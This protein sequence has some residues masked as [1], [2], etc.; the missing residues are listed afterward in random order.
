MGEWRLSKP[1]IAKADELTINSLLS[2]L[3]DLKMQR[4]LDEV[5]GDKIKEFG[6][7]KPQFTLEFQADG[8]THEI[9]FGHKVPGDQSIYAQKD[10]EARILLIRI[11]DKET[12]DRT[13]TD[14][15]TKKIF[16]LPPEKVTQ[17][18]LIRHDSLILQKTASSGWVAENN[19]PIKLRADKINSLI[20]Q[21][22]S[23]RALEFVAEKADDLKKYGL[24]PSP[25]L[26]LTLLTGDQQEETLLLG[27]K[28]GN[29]YYAQVSGTTPIT[30]VDQTLVEKL[31]SS[32]ETLEDRRLW[33]GPDTEI[34]K[35]VW[36][37]PNKL[38]TA[39]RDP[40]GWSM[41]NAD[42]SPARQESAM[43]FSLAFWRLKDLEFTKLLPATDIKKEKGSVFS[44][45][46][47][48]AEDK[49]LFKLEEFSEEKDLAHVT[50]SQGDKTSTGLIPAKSLNRFKGDSGGVGCSGTRATGEITGS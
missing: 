38:I 9:R 12:L 16:S 44:I 1:I 47:F 4:R 30:L 37:A 36:G 18:R 49:S 33:S 24:V 50:F 17:I 40:N 11:P 8:Q 10:A 43:K 32:Y 39:V 14:L 13:V 2:A 6:L 23:A 5:S 26:R 45:Q 25:A 46:L 3:T 21:I 35:V 28:Q 15:R 27:S 19:S 48:G 20:D 7:D 41:F 31:P 34:Q 29:R 42:N 22:S